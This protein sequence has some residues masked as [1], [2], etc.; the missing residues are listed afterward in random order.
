MHKSSKIFLGLVLASAVFLGTGVALLIDIFTNVPDFTVLRK[1]VSYS[2]ELANKEW[3]KREAGPETKSW[4]S[5]K[6]IS[7]PM[8]M[9]VI[10]SEDTSFFSHNGV[11]FHELREAIKKDWE[12]K[13]WARGGSTITQQVVKNV[14][15]SRQKTLWRKLKEFLWAQDMEKVLTKSEILVF[16][17]NMVEWGP[18]IYGIKEAAQHYFHVPPAML[19]AKQAAFLAMLLPSPKK[20]H[21]YYTKRALTEWAQKRVEQIL[22]VM[23]RMEFIDSETYD[24]A[25][26]EPLWGTAGV[27]RKGRPALQDIPEADPTTKE[28][29]PFQ[30][31]GTPPIGMP[32][33]TPLE[34]EEPEEET[35]NQEAA[36]ATEEKNMDT[37]SPESP[38]EEN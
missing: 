24:A 30:Q 27:S 18:N 3:S 9:A 19:S 34:A 23:N 16:Y 32:A 33:P 17:L 15:L 2:I 8:I 14:F 1:K 10:A 7:N 11:D 35:K 13:S 37:L 26:A 4:V 5:L 20:Y 28:E 29:E 38:S 36:P 12:K 22:T 31:P 25:L 6:Q 21:A